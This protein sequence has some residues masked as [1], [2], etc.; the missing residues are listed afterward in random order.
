MLRALYDK[1]NDDQI[2]E[3]VPF[4]LSWGFDLEA[5]KT[6]ISN[7]GQISPLVVKPH[8]DRFR[9][10]CGCRRRQALRE[11]GQDEYTVLILPEDT[12]PKQSLVLAL[13]ENLGHRSFNEAEKVLAL[14]RFLSLTGLG[15]QGLTALA[16]GRLDPETA[17]LLMAME[18]ADRT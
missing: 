12:T 4:L 10:I 15:D 8:R 3:E 16:S 18:S 17:E 11:L 13:E 1:V 14:R 9:L 6:S 5:L 7:V 2:E